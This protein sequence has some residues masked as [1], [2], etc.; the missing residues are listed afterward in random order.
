M[1][2]SERS[3]AINPQPHLFCVVMWML[4]FT[5]VRDTLKRNMLAT[6]VCST[7]EYNAQIQIRIPLYF[8]ISIYIFFFFITFIKRNYRHFF[9]EVSFYIARLTIQPNIRHFTIKLCSTCMWAIHHAFSSIGIELNR[10]QMKYLLS[11]GGSGKRK[12]D[13]WS[14]TI[15][16]TA[17]FLFLFFLHI[18]SISLPINRI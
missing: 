6:S 4:Y 10:R 18:H 7:D 8:A 17:T 15:C 9:G 16:R 5:V 3:K 13:L 12:K 14:M 1:T 11:V 2:M